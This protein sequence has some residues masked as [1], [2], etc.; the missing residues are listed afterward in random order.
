MAG[1]VIQFS[2][3]YSST[4]SCTHILPQHPLLE[5]PQPTPPPTKQRVKLQFFTF[6]LFQF[7]IANLETEI[8]NRMPASCPRI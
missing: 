2:T 4:L 8:L 1:L 6:L 7:S 5:H 3:S